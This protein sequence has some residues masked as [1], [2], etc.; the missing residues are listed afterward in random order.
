MLGFRREH[1]PQKLDNAARSGLRPAS[2][3]ISGSL[4]RP[5]ASCAMRSWVSVRRRSCRSG[6][7]NLRW[8]ANHWPGIQPA[9]QAAPER[10]R[11][12]ACG[13]ACLPAM[14]EL[15]AP[16]I[17]VGSCGGARIDA[18]VL[19]RN[20]QLTESGYHAQVHVE[21]QTSF[22]FLLENGR[23]HTLRRH[24]GDY[25]LNGRRFQA[26]ELM[27]RAERSFAQCDPAP[28]C[29]GFHPAHRR[30]CRRSGGAGVPGAVRGDLPGDAWAA[31]PWCCTAPGSRCSISAA[32]ADGRA[33]AYL[34]GIVFT[35]R[36]A[37][38]ERIA[39]KLVPPANWQGRS[40]RPGRRKCARAAADRGSGCGLRPTLA[41]AAE[42]N[43]QKI[44][45]QLA[46]IER[47]IG[48]RIVA[49]RGRARSRTMPPGCP[50]S[51]IPTGTCRS[52]SIRSF[53]FWPNTASI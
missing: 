35:G 24:E 4:P 39:A 45:Y 2:G 32:E 23:R 3:T 30:V 7:R 22:V 8:R 31:C 47:K 21:Q 16:A 48:A 51:F 46:K 52:A 41:A 19:E 42:K 25:V 34:W 26:E 49:A 44:E 38:R 13:S 50:G 1:Q 20:R 5:S 36:E 33:T 15:A 10:I 53:R 27:D 40:R 17:R 14:R 9:S 29:A 28:C 37:L 12:A 18:A 43:R 11:F 6:R